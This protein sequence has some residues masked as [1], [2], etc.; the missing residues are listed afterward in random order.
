M[1]YIHLPQQRLLGTSTC[2]TLLHVWPP[3]GGDMTS[4]AV[5]PAKRN[6]SDT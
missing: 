3:L 4:P 6:S 1:Q 5:M 2:I